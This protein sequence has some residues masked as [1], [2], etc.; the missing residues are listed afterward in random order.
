VNVLAQNLV[1]VA[2]R[3]QP[4]PVGPRRP[5]VAGC[6]REPA[7]AAPRQ[8]GNPLPREPPP[9]WDASRIAKLRLQLADLE[10]ELS[11]SAG[12]R[13]VLQLLSNAELTTL[14][15]PGHGQTL[16]RWRALSEVA[17]HDL[18]LAQ[19]FEAQADAIAIH[20]ELA[21]YTLPLRGIWGVW[22]TE[23]GRAR[24]VIDRATD[25]SGDEVTI[26]GRKAGCCGADIAT[27]AL[28]IARDREGRSRLVAVGLAQPGVLITL[29]GWC[30]VSM[31]AARSAD[32]VFDRAVAITVGEPDG[33]G[34]RPG[35][36]HQRGGIAACWYGAAAKLAETLRDAVAREREPHAAAHLGALDAALA[37]AKALLRE[38]AEA[39]DRDPASSAKTQVLEVCAAAEFA[40]DAALLHTGRA[41]GVGPYSRNGRFARLAADL[42]IFLRQSRAER[43]LE[44]LG[45]RIAND[46]DAPWQL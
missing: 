22:T 7:P 12:L 18:S 42:P 40:A 28:V 39:I 31:Q 11:S 1:A 19:L 41:L 6:A 16:T 4:A 43:D 2:T 17:A 36:W 33:Y 38:A 8:F 23:A 27:H 29:E 14:P 24:V 3:P 9:A 37:Q 21:R 34:T 30:G 45:R 10:S 44:S 20:D 5:P 26:S 13:R 32:V 25:Q 46:R 15:L 35:F